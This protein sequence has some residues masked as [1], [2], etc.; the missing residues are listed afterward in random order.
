[1]IG[2]N[3]GGSG[4]LTVNGGTLTNTGFFNVGGNAF[5]TLLVQ[6]G[7]SVSSTGTFGQGFDI[8]AGVASSGLVNVTNGMLSVSAPLIVGQSGQGQLVIGTAGN[9]AQTSTS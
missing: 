9:V 8:G 2:A 6:G 1:T 4:T 5:G 3:T 7:G